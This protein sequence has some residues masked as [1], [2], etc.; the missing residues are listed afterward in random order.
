MFKSLE[1]DKDPLK[2]RSA[3]CTALE[4]LTK[5]GKMSEL[6]LKANIE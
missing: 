5:P 2:I 3:S 6:P 4:A 1:D